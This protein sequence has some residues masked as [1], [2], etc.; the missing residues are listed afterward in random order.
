LV[1]AHRG[2]CRVAPENTL[3]AFRAAAALGADAVELD[4]RLSSDGHVVVHHDRTLDR[5]TSGTG[6]LSEKP[7]RELEALDA[8]SHFG[9]EF[10]GEKIPR[11]DEVLEAIAGQLLLNVHFSNYENPHDGLPESVVRLVQSRGLEERVLCSSFDPRGLLAVQRASLVIPC[12]LLVWHTQ[13]PL[14]RELLRRFTPCHAYHPQ[15]PG[16]SR[17]GFAREHARGRTV[18]AWT[19]NDRERMR[20]LMAWGV[21]GLITD[22]PDVAREVV[23]GRSA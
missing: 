11:L 4:A 17:D 2:A 9:A 7:L 1:I 8:G 21:D 3:S 14:Q 15:D 12:A 23:D 16:V 18:H 20:E 6:P 10:A 13:N 19:V 22:V 5:T